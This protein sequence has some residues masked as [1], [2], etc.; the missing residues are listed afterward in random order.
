M[1]LENRIRKLTEDILACE[2]DGKA[3]VLAE[4]LQD[5]LCLHV[6]NLRVKRQLPPL[7]RFSELSN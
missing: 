4:E 6:L 1:S 3:A 7:G 2:D 5:T